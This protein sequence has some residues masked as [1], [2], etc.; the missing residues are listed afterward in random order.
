MKNTALLILLILL[1]GTNYGQTVE[2]ARATGGPDQYDSCS[3]TL[4]DANGNVYSTGRFRQ[5]TNFDPGNTNI[6]EV[7]MLYGDV[8]VQKLSPTGS[9]LWVK[10][11]KS[12]FTMERSYLTLDSNNN[13]YV[14]SQFKGSIDLDPSVGIDVHSVLS[15]YSSSYVVKLNSNGD[16]IWGKHFNFG[17]T[18]NPGIE[19][20]GIEIDNNNNIL[21]TGE[22]QSSIDFDLGNTT[23]FSTGTPRNNFL[24]KMDSNGEFIWNKVFATNP[25]GFYVI[26]DIEIDS[27]NNI[28]LA[29]GTYGSVYLNPPT[30]N[31]VSSDIN[32]PD[33]AIVK[34]NENGGFLWSKI[35][36]GTIVGSTN[37]SEQ[38]NAIVVDA[39][40]NIYFS[41]YFCKKINLEP[42][43][44]NFIL[45]NVITNSNTS[46][47]FFGKMNSNGAMLW[48]RKLDGASYFNVSGRNSSII[49]ITDDGNVLIGM[50]YIGTFDYIING[51]S[52]SNTTYYTTSTGGLTGL[53]LAE[54]NPTNGDYLN[55]YHLNNPSNLFFSAFTTKNNYAYISGDFSF[56]LDCGNS[57]SITTAAGSNSGGNDA[58][59]IKIAYGATLDTEESTKLSDTIILYPNPVSNQLNISTNNQKINKITL[60]DFTGKNLDNIQV[61]LTKSTHNVDVSQLASGTYILTIFTEETI[62]SKKILKL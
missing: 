62:I 61:D 21:L 56:T 18:N 40:D 6:T 35:A 37:S 15:P 45:E 13:V 42:S 26:N 28:I 23:Q 32:F 49:E 30:G 51:V 22:F 52:G 36:Q 19:T 4:V 38:A 16:Y 1:T 7:A 20:N 41:G 58:F 12:E 43:N 60:S 24:M 46:S 57:V 47:P 44:T 5:T 53:S 14:T 10:V 50:N 29:G 55:M 9:F 2:W 48:A 25:Y 27:Q 3:T 8:Y 59:T 31:F 11:F 54:I 34:L 17:S 33:L 39:S